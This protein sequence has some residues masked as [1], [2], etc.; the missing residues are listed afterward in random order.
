[1]SDK[2]LRV[3]MADDHPIV[4]AGLKAL[5]QADPSLQIVGEARDGR[6]AQ[7]L[8]ASLGTASSMETVTTWRRFAC[9]RR[10]RVG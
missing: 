5:V 10:C 4:L 8:A 1:M 2:P 7:R 9:G 3:L 6:T